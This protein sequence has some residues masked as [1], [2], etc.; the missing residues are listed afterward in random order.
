M[1]FFLCP[2][3]YFSQ[4]HVIYVLSK[5]HRDCLSLSLILYK[6]NHICRIFIGIEMC[7]GEYIGCWKLCNTKIYFL[8]V[9]FML[10]ESNEC[11]SVCVGWGIFW[12]MHRMEIVF[13]ILEEWSES[14]KTIIRMKMYVLTNA[15]CQM[16]R[17]KKNN[18][19][20]KYEVIKRNFLTKTHAESADRLS[21]FFSF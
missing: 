1:L 7:M 13:A 15:E 6:L 18:N 16:E 10:V 2:S 5:A 19:K 20:L 12:M 4:F 8:C 14:T 11:V 3:F 21:L 17:T 9:I